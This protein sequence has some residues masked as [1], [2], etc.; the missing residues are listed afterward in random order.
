MDTQKNQPDDAFISE[1]ANYAVLIID[2]D[3]WI[4]RVISHYVQKWGF[5]PMSATD[6]IDGLAMAIK[7]RPILI[8]LDVYMPEING[9]TMLKMFKK[10]EYTQ[11]IPVIIISGNLSKE[12]LQSALKLGAAGF[13]SKPIS[14][15]IL[16]EK[17]QEALHPEHKDM[18]EVQLSDLSPDDIQQ[19][20]GGDQD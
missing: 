1:D 10:I 19:D 14:E 20:I 16:Y 2:D 15:Q 5:K 7:H 3:Q 9:Y 12:I 11:E 13:I 6:P 4:A 18:I 8:F 17:F